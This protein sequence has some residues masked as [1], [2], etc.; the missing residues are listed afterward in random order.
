MTQQIY[1]W[2]ASGKGEADVLA[3][4][5]E[6]RGGIVDTR[7]HDVQYLSFFWLQS[8]YGDRHFRARWPFL[9]KRTSYAMA[10]AEMT[11]FDTEYKLLKDWL[12]LQDAP[13]IILSPFSQLENGIAGKLGEM[14]QADGFIV[15]RWE[16]RPKNKAQLGLFA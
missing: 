3:I 5:D 16:R 10:R 15:E 7:K 14:L 6:T 4:T 1:L 11:P 2:C 13:A 8:M 9:T 12:R